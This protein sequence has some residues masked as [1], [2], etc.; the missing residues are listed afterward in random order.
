MLYYDSPVAAR[1]FDAQHEGDTVLLDERRFFLEEMAACEG[2]VLDMG[3]GTGRILLPALEQG[4]AIVGFDGSRVF[5]A[6]LAR[7]ARRMGLTPRVWRGDLETAALAPGSADLAIAAF[8]TFNHLPDRE[9]QLAFLRAARH[10]LHPDRGRLILNIANPDPLDVR[11][12]I[13]QKVLLRDDFT[14]PETGMRVA[15]WGTSQYD[16]ETGVIHQTFLYDLIDDAG[17]TRETYHL[18]FV[19]RWIPTD[20]MLALAGETGFEATERW[21]GFKRE[22][23]EIGTGD[24]VWVLR[25]G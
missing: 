23:Y 22:P 17:R 14:D 9:A 19:L 5:L 1:L 24:A 3:C 4:R 18:P 6:E 15:W 13:G 7:K 25:P 8:R 20:E 21:G 12:L 16:E 11:A 2:T 10:V